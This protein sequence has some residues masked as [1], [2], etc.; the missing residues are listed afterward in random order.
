[1]MLFSL[2][3]QNALPSHTDLQAYVSKWKTFKV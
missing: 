3:P 1:M 2:L